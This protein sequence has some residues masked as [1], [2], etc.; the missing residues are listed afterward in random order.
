MTDHPAQSEHYPS[1]PPYFLHICCQGVT[2]PRWCRDRGMQ[3]LRPLTSKQKPTNS[4]PRAVGT[5][6][7]GHGYFPFSSHTAVRERTFT[8]NPLLSQTRFLKVREER[9]LVQSHNSRGAALH[10]NPTLRLPA[11]PSSGSDSSG[12]NWLKG[13]NGLIQGLPGYHEILHKWTRKENEQRGMSSLSQEEIEQSLD[14]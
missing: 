4:L 8:S 14:R 3:G 5:T 9:V 6:L 2:R 10:L 7:P 13:I 11:Q 12:L 1:S